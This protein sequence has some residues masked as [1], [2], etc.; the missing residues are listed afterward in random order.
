MLIPVFTLKFSNKNPRLL[1]VG[2][3]DGTRACLT[4]ATTG[5]KVSPAFLFTDVEFSSELC[6][7]NIII[8]NYAAKPPPV[9]H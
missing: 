1:T 8:K 9:N 4:G 5:G 2:N 7:L 6:W 3:Y